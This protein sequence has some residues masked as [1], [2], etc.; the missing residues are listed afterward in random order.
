[1]FVAHF[2]IV[3]FDIEWSPVFV[4]VPYVPIVHES[5]F[6]L[7]SSSYSTSSLPL[8]MGT[9]TVLSSDMRTMVSRMRW[10]ILEKTVTSCGRK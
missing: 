8:L 5:P 6:T 2:S 9:Q 1:M 7:C 10:N 3:D 4:F